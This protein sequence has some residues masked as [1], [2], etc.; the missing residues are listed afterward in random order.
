MKWVKSLS[1]TDE[2]L[3]F[4]DSKVSRRS[5]DTNQKALHMMGAFV[6]ECRLVLAQTKVSDK[7]NEIT[8]IPELL[9]WLDLQGSCVTFDTAA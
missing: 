9:V 7:S 4:I 1:S 3:I 8:A 2:Q 5:F 6:S